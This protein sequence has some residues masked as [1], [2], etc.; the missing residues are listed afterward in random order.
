MVSVKKTS[1]QAEFTLN[2]QR[3]S[4]ENQRLHWPKT[5]NYTTKGVRKNPE[6]LQRV[7]WAIIWDFRLQAFFSG[8]AALQQ[9]FFSSRVP[10]LV[11]RT[12]PDFI[13]GFWH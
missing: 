9:F 12:G 10:D 5:M 8:G 6:T 7:G 2:N 11:K 3:G 4:V 1:Y 13:F